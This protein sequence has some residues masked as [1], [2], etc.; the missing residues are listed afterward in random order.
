MN[1]FRSGGMVRR[2]RIL[3]A[4]LL[5]LALAGTAST[6]LAGSFLDKPANR[7]D[8]PAPRDLNALDVRIPSTSG[9]TLAG[10]FVPGD[11]SRGGVLL[12]HGIHADRWALVSRARF[13]H[14]QGYSILMIDFQAHG[15]SPGKH[16]TFG[17]LESRDVEAAAVELGRRL[18]GEPLGVIGMS[19][20]GAA[21]LL[22]HHPTPFKAVVLESVYPTFE[23]AVKRRVAEY[24]GPLSSLVAPLLLVQL[25]P[26]LGIRPEDLRPIEHIADLGA[27]VFIISGS[28]DLHPTP[29]ESQ[30]LFQRAEDPMEYWEVPGVGHDDLYAAVSGEYE[31]RVGGFF[32]RFLH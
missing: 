17:Y 23:S 4:V 5:T 19:M 20:G 16:I 6:I 22:S 11:P 18:P 27:P 15:E 32:E 25:H 10:W 21:V 2:F 1:P 7:P 30:A 26:R 9:T 14:N 31:R 13:L 24:L 28:T 3:V 29:D 8:G 12:L